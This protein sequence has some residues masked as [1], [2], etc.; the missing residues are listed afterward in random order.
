MPDTPVRKGASTA[1]LATS[2][3]RHLA[4][5]PGNLFFSPYS[6]SA[7]LAMVQAGASGLTRAEIETAMGHTE[8]GERLIDAFS[9]LQRVLSTRAQSGPFHLSLANALWVQTGYPINTAFV[10]TLR[11]R[12]GAELKSADFRGAPSEAARGVN[13]WVDEATRGKIREILSESQLDPLTR[14]IL[15]NAIYFKAPWLSQF[16]ERATNPEP[17]HRLDGRSVH[18]PMMHDTAHRCY[19]RGDGFQ[20][21]EVPYGNDFV[22]MLVVLPDD[23]QFERVERE[24]DVGSV[25][26]LTRNVRPIEVALAL[27]RF[28]V[29]SSFALR[30][31]LARIGI[32]L[33][34]APG[35]D[36]TPV[37]TEPGFVLG[38]VLHKTVVDVDER[39]TEAAAVTAAMVLGASLH[40][41]PPKPIEY[42]VDRPFLFLIEDKPTGTILFMGRILDPSQ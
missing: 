28:R 11:N 37:S 35:A 33:A 10:E 39:G 8:T 24:L 36:F 23:G 40:F 12:L 27:P 5:D 4:S 3:Y 21:L 30:E 18:V 38:D 7:A 6:I 22:L 9:E 32:N 19:A 17:F 16:T 26:E 25:T 29:E 31:S 41:D 14:M 20:A 2:L 1:V 42:R 13:A 15:A 34:F